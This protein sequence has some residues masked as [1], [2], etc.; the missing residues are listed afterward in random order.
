MY[1]YAAM[2][3]HTGVSLT[4]TMVCTFQDAYEMATNLGLDMNVWVVRRA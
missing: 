3:K 1:I 2:N 4:S